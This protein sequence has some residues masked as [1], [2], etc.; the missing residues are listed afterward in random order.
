MILLNTQKDHKNGHQILVAT[1]KI[2]GRIRLCLDAR[3]IN[4]CIQRETYTTPT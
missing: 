2:D 3:E 4:S 1:P